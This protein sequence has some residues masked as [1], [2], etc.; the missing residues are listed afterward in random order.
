MATSH[1]EYRGPG[2]AIGGCVNDVA[3]GNFNNTT[4]N[5][6]PPPATN[7]DPDLQIAVLTTTNAM[8]ASRGASP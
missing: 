6:K 1:P 3:V 8:A 7:I 2:L 5:P 4:T